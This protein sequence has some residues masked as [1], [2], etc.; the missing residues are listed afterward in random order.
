[1]RGRYS[2]NVTTKGV[3][4]L[5][6]LATLLFAVSCSRPATEIGQ[7]V[8]NIIVVSIDALNRNALRAYNPGAPPLPH[9]DRFSESAVRFVNAYSSASWTLP[10]HGSL[11]TGL[12]PD[13]HGM[14]HRHRRRRAEVVT[15]ASKLKGAGFET[16]AFTGG[17]FVSR[18]FGFN[19]GFDRYDG[20]VASASWRPE[21]ELPGNG[22]R[23]G[24]VFDRGRAYLS[25]AQDTDAPFFLFLHTFA[26]HH[27]YRRKREEGPEERKELL[28]C[29]TNLPR[30]DA[31]DWAV[32]RNLYGEQLRSFDKSFGEFMTLLEEKGLFEST[33]VIVTSDHGEGFDYQSGRVH[34][35]GRLHEDLIRIPF[36]VGGPH[37]VSREAEEP[38]SLVDVAPTIFQLVAILQDP[39]LDGQPFANALYGLG[40]PRDDR[41]RNRRVLYAM[42]HAFQWRE[43]RRDELESPAE[44]PI[45][46]AVIRGSHYYIR[47]GDKEEL[48]STD[49]DPRQT[50][51]L[52]PGSPLLTQMRVLADARLRFRAKGERM[53]PNK[54]LEEHLRSLGY[55]H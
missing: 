47:E 21:L 48:Y 8:R 52:V 4:P 6:V 40:K 13:R 33:L 46:L 55:I 26:V 24:E 15:L 41:G 10:A 20:W 31:S 53:I 38:I 45:A 22:K 25:S 34:H 23:D 5:G 39:E 7:D 9:L 32:L 1:M 50:E 27:Y 54:E 17:V 28:S 2:A 42:E 19:K 36:L 18:E 16:V 3:G 29:L 30:C 44:R 49:S 14:V 37:L 35:G 12:Y 11:L 51:N 43:G